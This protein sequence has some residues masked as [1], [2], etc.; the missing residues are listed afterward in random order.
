[1]PRKKKQEASAV[2]D[3]SES[4][5]S[6]IEKTNPRV[7]RARAKKES[8]DKTLNNIYAS[9]K[10]H[11]QKSFESHK[12]KGRHWVWFLL[13]SFAILAGLAWLGFFLFNPS[14]KFSDNEVVFTIDAP[15]KISAGDTATF[16]ITYSNNLSIPLAT[17]NLFIKYP[18]GF[19]FVKADT[20]PTDKEHREW[21]LGTLPAK[22]SRTITIEGML[23]GNKDDV[24]TLRGFFNYRP[25]NFNADF[26]K[27]AVAD[28]A[29]EQS[30]LEIT[31]TGNES[32][33]IGDLLTYTVSIK[34]SNNKPFE[35]GLLAVAFP[36]GF[37]IQ[38]SSPSPSKDQNTWG[39]ST[40]APGEIS[41]ITFKGNFASNTNVENKTFSLAQ[42]ILH[43]DKK[44][45]GQTLTLSTKLEAAQ[46]LLETMVGTALDQQ[47][48][49]Q[50]DK[51]LFT[52]KY[53][54]TSTA[55]LENISLRATVEGPSDG[56]KSL[57]NWS[58][59]DDKLDGSIRGEQ[60]SSTV[61]RGT[62]TWTK[63]EIPALAMLK[64]GDEGIV[65]FTLP[66][67]DK[68][69]FDINKIGTAPSIA[70][71]ELVSGDTQNTIIMKSNVVRMNLMTNLTLSAQSQLKEKKQTADGG[72]EAIYIITWTVENSVH[73]A[74]DVHIAAQLPDGTR[75]L[76]K[77]QVTAGEITFDS[78][79]KQA[80]WK[81]NR[82]PASVPKTTISFDVALQ[83]PKGSSGS[84]NL[85]NKTRLEAYDKTSSA[86]ILIEKSALAATP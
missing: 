25:A 72:T 80:Q 3:M 66:I 22:T 79:T 78:D 20:E 63:K 43:G 40:L 7:Q 58:A 26:Q 31:F 68:G 32:A 83:A 52:I 69:A 36:Q 74:S 64:P 41:T 50:G 49:A 48:I 67:K 81:I 51:T 55:P 16:T 9:G 13:I 65:S 14:N 10:E 11:S 57:F 61:R 60:V 8:L 44:Y 28:V 4:E 18:D 38:N 33:H 86:S 2:S 30:P 56:G 84:F 42:L 59:I 24:A 23:W 70:Y 73:E 21:S 54:N 1:M 75:W 47:S 62:I 35:N 85:L 29:F 17:A 71:A 82:I 46:Y 76:D 19:E 27:V 34:N 45:T 39:I 77:T 53:K 15:K 6:K 37:I 5:L 12:K